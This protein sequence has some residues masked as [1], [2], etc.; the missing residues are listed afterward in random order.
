MR[1][2][3]KGRRSYVSAR[4][5]IQTEAGNV[6]P[7][8]ETN[9]R[10]PGSCCRMRNKV[11]GSRGAVAACDNEQSE[12]EQDVFLRIVNTILSHLSLGNW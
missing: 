6:L 7:R 8:A 1:K 5:N 10:K 9:H 2:Q 12:A 4:G 11:I 3:P